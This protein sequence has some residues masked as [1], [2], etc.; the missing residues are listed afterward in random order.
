MVADITIGVQ[1]GNN[2]IGIRAFLISVWRVIADIKH[3]IVVMAKVQISI[4][5]IRFIREKFVG[6]F[7]KIKKAL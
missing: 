7:I 4:T 6:I 5:N 3:P 2:K 1:N